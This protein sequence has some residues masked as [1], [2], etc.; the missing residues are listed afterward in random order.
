MENT[1]VGNCVDDVTDSNPEEEI[2]FVEESE[3]DEAGNLESEGSDSDSDDESAKEEVDKGPRSF[4]GRRLRLVQRPMNHV[5]E[6]QHFQGIF[7]DL[8]S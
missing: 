7:G 3:P 5:H 4:S 8:E 6:H 2:I 1:G